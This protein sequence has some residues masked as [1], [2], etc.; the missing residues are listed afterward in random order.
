MQVR[1]GSPLQATPQAHMSL[2]GDAETECWGEGVMGRAPS[3]K[4]TGAPFPV[5]CDR[6]ATCEG[7]L[8][9]P[10]NS[11]LPTFSRGLGVH[12]RPGW[13]RGCT[14]G[15]RTEAFQLSCFVHFYSLALLPLSVGTWVALK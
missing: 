3:C 11:Q 6:Q 2:S 15:P 7:T 13:S 12:C 10:E 4:V 5:P 1:P 14:R 8:W 9:H